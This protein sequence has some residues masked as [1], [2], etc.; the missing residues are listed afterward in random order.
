VDGGLS[1]TPLA[2]PA[3]LIDPTSTPTSP[4]PFLQSTNASVG[5]DRSDNFY[6]VYSEH[7]ADQSAGA[8]VLQK[9]SLSGGVETQLIT[10]N[11]LYEWIVDSAINPVMT[12]DDN[13]PTFT[14]PTT[15]AVQNDP[16]SGDIYVTW[17]TSDTAPTGATNFNPNSI[18]LIQ[19]SDGGNSFGGQTVI[20]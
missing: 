18:V 12:V 1:W 16:F 8:I 13:L 11:V 19:S 20:N 4:Q 2:M 7:K 5:F 14:D 3:N 15:G 17:S 10:N 6:I 9:F